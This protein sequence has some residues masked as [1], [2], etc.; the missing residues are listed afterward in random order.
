MDKAGTRKC[1]ES[2]RGCIIY[3]RRSHTP[4]KMDLG[5]ETSEKYWREQALIDANT[6]RELRYQHGRGPCNIFILDTSASLGEDGF[7]LMKETF[8]TILTE[9]ANHPEE[10]ENVA[11]IICGKHTR[12]LHYFSNQYREISRSLDC[13]EFGGLSPLT[14]AFLLCLGSTHNGASHTSV[15]CEFRIRPRIILISDGRPTNFNSISDADDSVSYETEEAK[16]HLQTVTR[17]VGRCH[18]IF[19]IP[20]GKNPDMLFLEFLCNRSRGGKIVYPHEAKQ[21]A[22]YS[23]NLRA[24][25]LMSSPGTHGFM[26]RE[27]LLSVLTYAHP[28]KVFT[29]MD[30]E[31]IFDI[32]MKKSLYTSEPLDSDEEDE[33]SGTTNE[34]SNPY[35]PHLGTRVKRGPDWKWKNQDWHGPGTVIG[36]SK[37]AGWL[38]VQWDS[39]VKN[40][41]RHG[42]TFLEGH[43]YDVIA[44]DIPRILEDEII[45]TGCLVVRGPDWEWEDQDGGEGNIGSVFRVL[46]N[47]TVYVR[48]PNGITGNYRF[49]CQGKF[50][51]QL[52][53][54]FSSEAV[55]FLQE[56]TRET[57]LNTQLS[58]SSD[59]DVDASGFQKEG[60]RFCVPSDSIS[61]EKEP[62]ASSVPLLKVVKGVYYKNDRSEN[63][64]DSSP[65]LETDAPVAFNQWMWRDIGGKWNSY[66]R[67]INNKINKCYQRNPNATVIVEMGDCIIVMGKNIQ[68]NLNTRE[69]LEVKLFKD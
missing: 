39:G 37:K 36:Y 48:W 8:C 46:N 6:N 66:P 14:G 57:V 38:R 11:A 30:K 21:F 62:S 69:T 60:E 25:S 24:A 20:V 18:P 27:L 32:C 16:D 1:G 40:V 4:I 12:F 28:G 23:Q 34:K 43:K 13:V 26:D 45:G 42:E 22:R 67:K 59:F 33:E 7:L 58:H 68:I 49:G 56:E 35:M 15:M 5:F 61:G 63:D 17:H 50:D 53:D 3:C 2:S 44:C 54:P 64:P 29:E 31:D 65:D 47:A 51:L 9:F 19:C 10:D 41:Y 52:C 55:R